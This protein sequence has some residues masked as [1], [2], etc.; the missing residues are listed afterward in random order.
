MAGHSRGAASVSELGVRSRELPRALIR[1]DPPW[2]IPHQPA[3]SAR[4]GGAVD[5][6]AER[7]KTLERKSLDALVAESQPEHPTWDKE[8]LR[9][10]CL[11]KQQLDLNFLTV[12]R[13]G[14]NWQEI[15]RGIACPTLLITA[16]SPGG[17]V[18]AETAKQVVEM[19]DVISHVHISGT[20]HHI[21]FENYDDYFAAFIAFLAKIT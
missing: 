9:T 19:N 3:D 1:E 18:S 20:G 5:P 7:I 13:K 4:E 14:M 2:R 16:D 10:W 12:K 11:A 21:R 6:F 15:V 8:V 17:I